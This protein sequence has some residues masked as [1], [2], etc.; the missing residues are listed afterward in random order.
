[1]VIG[2]APKTR[3]VRALCDITKGGEFSERCVFSYSDSKEI[4]CLKEPQKKK[5]KK[6][7]SIL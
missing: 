4:N 6:G 7:G 2:V 1:M 5:K 3:G